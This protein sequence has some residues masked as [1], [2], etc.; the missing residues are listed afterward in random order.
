MRGIPLIRNAKERAEAEA[1]KTERRGRELQIEPAHAKRAATMT[2]RLQIPGDIDEVS[3]L[4]RLS[5][6]PRALNE[7]ERLTISVPEAGA[8]L[9]I[10]RNS[11]Y[12]AAKRRELP[13]IKFGRRLL[14]PLAA[15]RRILGQAGR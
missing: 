2:A 12:E 5:K 4:T 3:P 11:A 10:G 14:V 13:T 6:L 15:L 7:N 1:R 9:G 8:L